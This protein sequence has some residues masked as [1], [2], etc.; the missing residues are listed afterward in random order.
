MFASSDLFRKIYKTELVDRSLNHNI[1][2]SIFVRLFE[3][4]YQTKPS[5]YDMHMLF[6][7]IWKGDITE[8]HNYYRA[9]RL[10][11][12]PPREEAA[13]DLAIRF[14]RKDI[15]KFII[16]YLNN[17]YKKNIEKFP[18]GA[19]AYKKVIPVKFPK[20]EYFNKI[21]IFLEFDNDIYFDICVHTKN[22]QLYLREALSG[23]KYSDY[24]RRIRLKHS[25][26]SQ[27][28]D[29]I[30][31]Y[32]AN[33]CKAL[34]KLKQ[35][36][37]SELEASLELIFDYA[38][39]NYPVT[40]SNRYKHRIS[41]FIDYL[42]FDAANNFD[43]KKMMALLQYGADP[44]SYFDRNPI[45]QAALFDGASSAVS[46]AKHQTDNE[47]SLFTQVANKNLKKAERVFDL[48]L[49]YGADP[50]LKRKNILHHLACHLYFSSNKLERDFYLNTVRKLIPVS[51][52]AL[53]CMFIHHEFT[54]SVTNKIQSFFN[55]RHYVDTIETARHQASQN[56]DFH[57]KDKSILSIETHKVKDLSSNQ[58]KV[59]AQFFAAQP[60]ILVDKINKAD[61]FEKELGS[62]P[63][64]TF[65]DTIRLRNKQGNKLVGVYVYEYINTKLNNKPTFIHYIK[66]TAANLENCPELI[67]LIILMR[68]FTCAVPGYD[69][70]SFA[71]IASEFGFSLGANLKRYPTHQVPEI[72]MKNLV[73]VVKNVEPELH[74]QYYYLKD[75][76]SVSQN[77]NENINSSALITLSHLSRKTFNSEYFLPGH[78]LCLAF[79]NDSDNFEN[80]KK[81]VLPVFGE[82]VFNHLFSYY[83]KSVN[84]FIVTSSCEEAMSMRAKL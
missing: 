67:K 10:K 62:H 41:N 11:H 82:Q 7:A 32:L 83:A 8:V 64:T 68:G 49:E 80:F 43:Y 73:R 42:L 4:F 76:M 60:N 37:F 56:A 69:S 6:Y 77:F 47:T 9:N 18:P 29:E 27:T 5:E 31:I 84:E 21:S 74:G 2:Q 61:Y 34:N 45:L 16:E 23:W 12:Y 53:N 70:I 81:A 38:K 33:I 72:N 14:E 78:A 65:V 19:P 71:E 75:E 48:L 3:R 13:I 26:T 36:N 35:E 28:E 39:N 79:K 63:D 25:Y 51:E 15:A 44:H 46:Q 50:F 55:Q 59:L 52:Q 66:L 24:D 58:R 54:Q 57:L 40:N 22:Q 17:G 30:R 1:S 20:N